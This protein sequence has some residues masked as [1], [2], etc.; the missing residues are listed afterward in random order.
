MASKFKFS[1]SPLRRL[2][3]PR[4]AVALAI[5]VPFSLL[6]YILNAGAFREST[7]RYPWTAAQRYSVCTPAQYGN[8]SWTPRHNVN[9]NTTVMTAPEDALRFSGFEGCASSREF[10]WHLAADREEQYN[11]FPAAQS[12]DW[13]PGAGCE[14]LSPLYPEALV[15]Q[16]VEDGG[17]Y[18]VGGA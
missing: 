7:L 6:A 2:L 11:R 12:W 4:R 8:G 14:G 13:I 10:F 5:V 15:R 16:L 18:L 1:E 3:T 9:A 17:W